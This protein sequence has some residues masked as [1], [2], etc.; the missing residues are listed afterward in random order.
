MLDHHLSPEAQNE[1]MALNNLEKHTSRDD[2]E[3][4]T[5]ATKAARGSAITSKLDKI[6]RRTTVCL[7]GLED[8]SPSMAPKMTQIYVTPENE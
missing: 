5:F 4:R 8:R 1:R 2:F 7:P 6:K 3:Q